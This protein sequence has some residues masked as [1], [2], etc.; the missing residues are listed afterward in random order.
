[1]NEKKCI[2]L[3][4]EMYS[5]CAKKLLRSH[6]SS[7]IWSSEHECAQMYH[8]SFSR[9]YVTYLHTRTT[10]MP[11]QTLQPSKL[12][13]NCK[14]FMQNTK[15]ILAGPC[16][17]TSEFSARRKM[18]AERN[19]KLQ[20]RATLPTQKSFSRARTPVASEPLDD[21]PSSRALWLQFAQTAEFLSAELRWAVT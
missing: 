12:I 3:N 18:Q 5:T 1:M 9:N 8:H 13:K 14:A 16:Y 2:R 11:V 15:Y 6:H 19:V 4:I 7:S 21:R 10:K 20:A 17:N